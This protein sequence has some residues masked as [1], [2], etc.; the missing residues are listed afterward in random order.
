[1]LIEL[2][3]FGRVVEVGSFSAAAR[4]LGVSTSTVSRAVLRL[5]QKLHSRLVLPTSGT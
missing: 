5:E 3:L 2:D 1:M 4:R